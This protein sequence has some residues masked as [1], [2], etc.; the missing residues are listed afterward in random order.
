MSE[1]EKDADS[2]S[3]FDDFGPMH[4]VWIRLERGMQVMLGVAVITMFGFLGESWGGENIPYADIIKGVLRVSW[5]FAI[6]IM[7]SPIV[8]GL[9]LIARRYSWLSRRTRGRI[10]LLVLLC[11]LGYCWLSLYIS[12][13]DV[14]KALAAATG[15]EDLNW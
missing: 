15:V 2:G 4:D 3:W 1:Q 11:M 7:T 6:S 14:V 10:Y 5:A 12:T 8:L 13:V 9:G